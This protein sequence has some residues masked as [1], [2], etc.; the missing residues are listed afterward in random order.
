MTTS[1]GSTALS[2]AAASLTSRAMAL[3]FLKPSPSFWALS[4]VLQA[5]F[6]E[7]LLAHFLPP[8]VATHWAWSKLLTN[9]NL[10]ASLAENLNGRLGDC[11][12]VSRSTFFTCG[13]FHDICPDAP[14]GYKYLT[15]TGAQQ[16]SL[17]ARDLLDHDD[18]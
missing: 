10:D 15:E 5:G 13:A 12:R 2:R 17:G 18:K 4:R 1:A 11:N 8:S 6:G 9:G 14:H 3:V 7:G 16:E